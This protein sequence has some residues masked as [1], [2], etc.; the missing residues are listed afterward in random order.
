[1][2]LRIDVK[3]LTNACLATVFQSTCFKFVSEKVKQDEGNVWLSINRAC[4]I[5]T[6]RRDDIK[7]GK[8]K[9]RIPE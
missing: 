1:M 2:T 9:S 4:V 3:Q 5:F 8:E 7:K 6:K